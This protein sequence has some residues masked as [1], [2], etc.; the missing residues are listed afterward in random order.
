MLVTSLSICLADHG[1]L[2]NANGCVGGV[3]VSIAAFQRCKQPRRRIRK[4]LS[5]YHRFFYGILGL[6]KIYFCMNRKAVSLSA[7]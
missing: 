5:Q 3:V 1:I 2:K 4:W 6:K 7:A